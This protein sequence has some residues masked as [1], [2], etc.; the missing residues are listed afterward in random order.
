[1]YIR[2]ASDAMQQWKVVFDVVR[3]VCVLQVCKI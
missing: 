2:V 1:M 3:E